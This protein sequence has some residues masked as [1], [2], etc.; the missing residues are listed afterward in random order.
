MEIL[1]FYG[2]IFDSIEIQIRSAPQNDRLNLSFVKDIYAI[3]EKVARKG[4]K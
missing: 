3:A 1:T 2:I 4:R